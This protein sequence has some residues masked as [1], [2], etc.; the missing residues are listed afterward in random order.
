MYLWVI[1]AIIVIVY[2]LKS[3]DKSPDRIDLVI[4]YYRPNC[5]WCEL[6]KPEWKKIKERFAATKEINTATEK[7]ASKHITSVPTIEIKYYKAGTVTYD[8]PRTAEAILK[9]LGVV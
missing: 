5:P 4:Y 3:Q 2:Y 7:E 6:F 9:K 8:G 1:I